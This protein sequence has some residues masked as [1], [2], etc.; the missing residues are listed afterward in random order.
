[1]N[2]PHAKIA[3]ECL[4]AAYNKTASFPEI[5]GRLIDAGFD[6][7]LVDYRSNTTTY[8]LADAD[9]IVLANRSSHASIG[10]AFDQAAIAAQVRWAQANPPDYSYLAFSTNVKASGCAGYVVSFS[11]KRVLYFG[12]TAETH[13]EHFPR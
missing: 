11:G 5:V 13:V 3:Q 10:R 9:G 7:Y 1:M 2:T 4:D 8:Y 6:G 12:A